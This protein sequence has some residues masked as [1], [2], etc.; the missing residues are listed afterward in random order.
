MFNLI[1]CTNCNV[2]VCYKYNTSDL[3]K[4]TKC[5]Y[6]NKVS[7]M[8]SNNIQ[9]SIPKDVSEELAFSE[10]SIVGLIEYPDFI[11]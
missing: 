10:K 6:V 8:S 1:R 2:N 11:S 9:L 3:V 5:G 7:K 4:C